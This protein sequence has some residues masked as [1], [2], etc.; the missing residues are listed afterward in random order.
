MS[1]IITATEILLQENIS[2]AQIDILSDSQASLKSL[3]NPIT[4]SDLVRKAKLSLNKLGSQ[5]E[6]ILH[7]IEAHEGWEYNE[8]ADK[9]AKAGV[10]LD[11]LPENEPAPNKCS[12]FTE[13]EL[14]IRKAWEQSFHDDPAFR[15]SKYFIGGP[16]KVRALL[17]LNHPRE[18][19]GRMVRFLTGH[20]FLRHH[21]AIVLQGI[22]PPLGD[23]SCRLCRDPTM[24]ETSHHIITECDRL[25][26][27]RASTL[28]VYVGDEVPD[29]DPKSLGKFL[30]HKEIILLETDNA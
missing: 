20:A 21:N 14:C 26:N 17:L 23:N 7:Y 13:I 10:E 4:K 11:A 24:D 19:L 1:A 30:S 28:G 16:S 12:I 29:W 5:N 18:C 22:N 25:C 2:N 8:I 27:W 15:Q 6:L 3:L 9:M